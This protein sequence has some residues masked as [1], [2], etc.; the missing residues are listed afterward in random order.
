MYRLEAANTPLSPKLKSNLKSFL[1]EPAALKTPNNNSI[2]DFSGLETLEEVSRNDDLVSVMDNICFEDQS[3]NLSVK[4]KR[5][6]V[7]PD[8][9]LV[10]RKRDKSYSERRKRVSNFFKT[11]INYFSNRRRTIDASSFD[12]SLNDSVVS[13]STV[14][15]AD[16]VD[17][18]NTCLDA[19]PRAKSRK[20]KKNLFTRTFSSSRFARSKS[21]KSLMGAEGDSNL[22]ASCF[23]DISLN[24]HSLQSDNGS[25][26]AAASRTTSALA[27]LTSIS[28]TRLTKGP[29]QHDA[30]NCLLLWSF[31]WYFWLVSRLSYSVC[32]VKWVVSSTFADLRGLGQL[33]QLTSCLPSVSCAPQGSF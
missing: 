14:F 1:S 10:K 32:P 28:S 8:N 2:A 11:P 26:I 33:Y 23:P 24:P 19:T 21:N 31:N 25:E 5:K 15:A 30:S 13:T 17:N 12:H 9:T 4:R 16:A 6:F 20:V 22:N 29:A 3:L 18:L 27:V 7:S